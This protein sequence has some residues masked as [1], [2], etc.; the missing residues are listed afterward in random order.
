MTKFSDARVEHHGFQSSDHRPILL[1]FGEG[2]HC[3]KHFGKPFRFESFWLKEEDLVHVIIKAWDD[4]CPSTTVTELHSKLSWSGKA[5]ETECNALFWCPESL[6]VWQNSSFYDILSDFRNLSCVDILNGLLDRLGREEFSFICVL[7]WCLWNS[8]NAALH[9]GKTRN[10]VD[11]IEGAGDIL[12]EFQNTYKAL[13]IPI[14]PNALNP[15]SWLAPPVGCLKLNSDASVRCGRKSIGVGAVIRD[16]S[17]RVV[18]AISKS[19]LGNFSVEMAE[20]LALREGLILAKRFNLII[21]SAEVDAVS[22]ASL[23]NSEESY[24]G[25]ALFLISDIKALCIE[26]G[27][28]HCLAIPSSA[29]SLAHALVTLAFSSCEEPL[30]WDVIPLVFFQGYEYNLLFL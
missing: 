14:M 10:V 8:R 17:G 30:W 28:C 15:S 26:V 21:S 29:N 18:A 7:I 23:L 6:K 25:D 9:R 4:K 3:D 13:S 5:S 27:G 11:I 24:L 22:V 16:S 1:T 2:T 19:L 12:L 20:L